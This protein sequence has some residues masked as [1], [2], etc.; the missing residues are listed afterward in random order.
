MLAEGKW[1]IASCIEDWESGKN[2]YYYNSWLVTAIVKGKMDWYRVHLY[3]GSSV[4]LPGTDDL[5]VVRKKLFRKV[6]PR[7]GYRRD[8]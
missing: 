4:N 7:H 8:G 3:N 6:N 1:S 5:M 2:V